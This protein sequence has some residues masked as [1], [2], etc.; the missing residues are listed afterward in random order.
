MAGDF[1]WVCEALALPA[2]AANGWETAEVAVS[3]ADR[4][5]PFGATDPDSVQFF[6]GFRV[7]AGACVPQA[8]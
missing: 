7:E 4:E 3:L 2:L 6:E 5:V 1:L 8:F